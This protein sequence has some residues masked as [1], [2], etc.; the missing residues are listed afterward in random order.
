VLAPVVARETRTLSAKPQKVAAG[1]AA[2]EDAS[3]IIR[4]GA[5]RLRALAEPAADTARLA[6][7]LGALEDES[8][9]LRSYAS[10]LRGHDKAAESTSARKFS[11]DSTLYRSMARSYGFKH[12]GRGS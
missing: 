10:A 8:S 2:L 11:A 1:A 4:R 9:A 7:M 6:K 3:A 12:C 5:E